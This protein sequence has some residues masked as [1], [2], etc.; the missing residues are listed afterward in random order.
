MIHVCILALNDVV[1]CENKVAQWIIC[2]GSAHPVTMKFNTA[3]AEHVIIELNWHRSRDQRCKTPSKSGLANRNQEKN[4]EF[5]GF[6]LLKKQH[7][8]R[9]M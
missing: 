2:V 9:E 6:R 1:T 8:P 5:R 3:S 4:A 7:H